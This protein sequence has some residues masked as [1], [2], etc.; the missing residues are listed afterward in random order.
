MGSF[1]SSHNMYTG[2]HF[3]KSCYIC[4]KNIDNESYVICVTCKIKLHNDCEEKYRDARS[5]CLCP[6]CQKIGSLGTIYQ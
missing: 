1:I 2:K 4:N 3:E 6:K 5:Y